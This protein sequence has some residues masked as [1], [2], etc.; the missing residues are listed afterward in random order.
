MLREA[1]LDIRHGAL[2]ESI[3]DT[4]PIGLLVLEPIDYIAVAVPL[5]FYSYLERGWPILCFSNTAVGNLVQ[6]HG[7]GWVLEPKVEALSEFF[8]SGKAD[9]DYAII[10]ENIKQYIVNNQWANRVQKLTEVIR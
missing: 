9:E 5:K 1:D 4:R 6:E 8:D 7:L 10:Q 3:I 2:P